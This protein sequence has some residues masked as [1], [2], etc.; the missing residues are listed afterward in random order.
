M[1]LHGGYYTTTFIFKECNS[2]F[3]E[4]SDLVYDLLNFFWRSMQSRETFQNV[5]CSLMKRTLLVTAY[6]TLTIFTIAK[7]PHGTHQHSHQYR[8]SLNVWTGIVNNNLIGSY[9]MP[10]L[11]GP[12]FLSRYAKYTES[13]LKCMVTTL[14]NFYRSRWV[15]LSSSVFNILSTPF[16]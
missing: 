4:T 8:F 6:L 16:L 14:N 7:N 9:L 13:V 15:S 12:V 11:S 1:E 10:S 2:Y 3:H 5:S